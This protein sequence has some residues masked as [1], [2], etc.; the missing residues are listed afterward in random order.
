METQEELQKGEQFETQ[1]LSHK[2]DARDAFTDAASN[3]LML[4]EH[5]VDDVENTLHVDNVLEVAEA[6]NK[7]ANLR[8]FDFKAD[9]EGKYEVYEETFTY[10][11]VLELKDLLREGLAFNNNGRWT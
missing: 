7:I 5:M 2:D 11:F 8:Y 9:I 1:W 4:V 10:D 3:I 6:I